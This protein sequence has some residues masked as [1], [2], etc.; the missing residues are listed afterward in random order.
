[1]AEVKNS[2]LTAHNDTDM[3]KDQTLKLIWT[4]NG[5]LSMFTLDPAHVTEDGSRQVT[6]L[7]FDGLVTLDRNGPSAKTSLR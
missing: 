3:A 4:Q 5:S 2:Q 6:S 1:M 7:L